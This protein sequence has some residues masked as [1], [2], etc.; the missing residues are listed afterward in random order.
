MTDFPLCTKKKV[1][2]RVLGDKT[3]TRREVEAWCYG[4]LCV[5]RRLGDPTNW[6][7]YIVPS[8]T[9]MATASCVFRYEHTAVNAMI[10]IS[11]LKNSWT[12]MDSD[13]VM[14]TAQAVVPIA[15]KHGGTFPHA[16]T[17]RGGP[18]EALRDDLNGPRDDI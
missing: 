2:L 12:F 3:D 16:Q 18:T 5:S 4:D 6:T 10:E 14:K 17:V 15:Q 9:S 11:K 7:I 8:G 1:F 13:E